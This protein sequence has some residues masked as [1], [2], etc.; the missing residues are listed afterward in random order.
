MP[1]LAWVAAYYTYSLFG[2][3]K[4]VDIQDVEVRLRSSLTMA[5]PKHMLPLPMYFS[6]PISIGQVPSGSSSVQ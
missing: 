1:S 5:L 6:T 4:K 3:A 2:P